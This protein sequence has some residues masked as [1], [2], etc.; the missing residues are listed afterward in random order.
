LKSFYNKKGLTLIE[1]LIVVAIIGVLAAV[2]IPKYGEMLEKANL[3]AT[4]GNL[5][6][7]RSAVSMYYGNFLSLPETLDP[8]ASQDIKQ[9]IGDVLPYVKAKKPYSNSPYGN[10]IT[11]GQSQPD[12]MGSGWYYNNKNGSVFINSIANDIYGHC[13]TTY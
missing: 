12:T 11:V 2:A 13:Y 3:G 10:N 9:I 7:L 8:N 6:T 1:L 5:G 4:L